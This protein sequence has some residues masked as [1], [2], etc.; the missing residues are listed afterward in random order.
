M[1]L[2]AHVKKEK[3]A[4]A[5]DLEDAQEL[6][7]HLALHGDKQMTEIDALTA[8]NAEL[9]RRLEEAE[10]RARQETQARIAAQGKVE[11]AQLREA[12]L[13]RRRSLIFIP[14]S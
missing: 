3:A 9:E 6:N 10:Q 8:R 5:E 2:L 13:A 12:A 11:A 7:Q 1:S 14:C 4:Q